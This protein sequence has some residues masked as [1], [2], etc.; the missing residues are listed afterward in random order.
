MNQEVFSSHDGEIERLS[1]I[2]KL[3]NLAR[4]V[5]VQGKKGAGKAGKAGGPE[6]QSPLISGQRQG[7]SP[8][9]RS[10]T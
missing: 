1:K 4:G 7:W 3:I 6:M 9:R 10:A 2:A 8:G 5:G